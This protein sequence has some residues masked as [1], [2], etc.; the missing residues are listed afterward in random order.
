MDDDAFAVSD[1]PRRSRIRSLLNKLLRSINRMNPKQRMTMQATIE[2]LNASVRVLGDH[3]TKLIEVTKAYATSIRK[4]GKVKRPIQ[5]PQRDNLK[6]A[7]DVQSDK[8][9]NA[10]T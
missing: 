10:A 3:P 8:I 4:T 6:R 2:A 9:P 5:Y 7:T 1:F